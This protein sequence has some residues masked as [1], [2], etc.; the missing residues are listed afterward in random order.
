MTAAENSI[1][2]R[3]AG[4]AGTGVPC[5]TTTRGEPLHAL[6]MSL[7][8]WLHCAPLETLPGASVGLRCQLHE[9]TTTGGGSGDAIRASAG[10]DDTQCVCSPCLRRTTRKRSKSSRTG[11]PHG[12]STRRSRA[13][14]WFYCWAPSAVAA[15]TVNPWRSSHGDAVL[16]FAVTV[17]NRL[18]A[19]QVL[20]QSMDPAI[21]RF[22]GSHPTALQ[23]LV[24][25]APQVVAL[26]GGGSDDAKFALWPRIRHFVAGYFSG[27]A[28]RG[29]ARLALGCRHWGC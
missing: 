27:C 26:S 7:S 13:P 19:L 24:G 20:R 16:P 9:H 1:G 17:H 2:T 4:G 29:W 6:H 12:G 11:Q 25:S 10:T 21:H 5:F 8:S 22:P 18:A 28:V 23:C 15:E 3:S 14:N